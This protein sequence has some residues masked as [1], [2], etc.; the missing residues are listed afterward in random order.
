MTS[1]VS[2]R[3]VAYD[4][5]IRLQ[6]AGSDSPFLAARLQFQESAALLNQHLKPMV[7]RRRVYPTMVIPQASGRVGISDPPLGNFTADPSYGPHGLRDVVRPDLGTKWICADFSAV[8]SRI[9]VHRSQDPIDTEIYRQKWDIHSATLVHILWSTREHRL[10]YLKNMPSLQQGVL[11]TPVLDQSSEGL[12]SILQSAKAG[13][14]ELR[15]AIEQWE[16]SLR[17]PTDPTGWA[18]HDCAPSQWKQARQLASEFRDDDSRPAHGRT[19]GRIACWLAWVACGGPPPDWGGSTDRRRTLAKNV[20]YTLQYSLNTKAMA[21]YA[22][23]LGMASKDLVSIGEA[24]L[25]AKP[26][27]VQ[28][29]RQRWAEAVRRKEARTAFGRRRR[30]LGDERQIMKEGLNHEIQ[31][32]VADMMKITQVSLNMIGCRMVL[33]RHDGWY[34]E[35]PEGWDRMSDYKAIVEREWT[36]DGRPFMCPAEYETING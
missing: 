8:E 18:G 35:V 1:K 14:D 10:A 31:G 5:L 32:T 34:S 22:V 11:G 25:R 30:L 2:S 24:Y 20:R 13:C 4:Q 19:Q 36:I 15:P 17:A 12:L 7:G 27:L 9:V 3:S 29:K 6:E 16:E 23:E 28:W 33:Q 26:W 21:R